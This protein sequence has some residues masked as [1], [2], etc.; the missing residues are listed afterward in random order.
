MEKVGLMSGEKVLVASNTSG[1]RVETY[2]IPGK[3]DS[4][5]V[6]MNGASA[7]AIKKDEQIIIMGFELSDKPIEAKKFL[8]M[9]RTSSCAFFEP[10]FLW[11]KRS[12]RI[13]ME[14]Q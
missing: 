7:H 11:R 13:L 14:S 4:G 10:E 1:A 5:F 6:A 2:V 3:R 12:K 9:I 8:L